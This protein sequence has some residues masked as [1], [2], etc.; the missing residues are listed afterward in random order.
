MAAIQTIRKWGVALLIVIGLGLFAFIAEDFF[1]V[2]DILFGSDKRHVGQVYS[3][4]LG[5]N[6]YQSMIEE[7]TE[8]IKFTRGQ[9]SLSDAEQ[10]QIK[11]QVWQTYVT[12]KLVE[13]E[14]K[15]LGLTVTDEELNNVIKTGTNSMLMQTPFVNKQTGRFDVTLLKQFLDQY[16]QMQAKPDQ[17][18]QEYIEYYQKLYNYWAFIEK[19]LRSSLLNDKYQSL[20]GRSIVSNPISAKLAYEG[21]S[22]KSDAVVASIPYTSV[23]DNEVTVS[24]DDI[25]KLYDQRKDIFKQFG[26]S[27][28]IKYIGIQVTASPDDKA[29][30]EKEM[31]SYAADLEKGENV[32]GIVSTSSSLVSYASLPVSKKAFPRDIQ[33]ELDSMSIG[34]MKGPYLNAADNTLNI[35]KVISTSQVPDSV[36]YRA[37]NCANATLEA[38]GSTADSIIKAIAAGG[39]FEDM[40]KKYNQTGESQWLVSSQYEGQTLDADNSKFIKSIINGATNVVQ[41]VELAQNVILIEVLD[42]KAITTKY[43]AAVIKRTI[44]FSKETYSKAYNA[45]SHFVASNNTLEKMEANA[46]KS[47]YTVQERKD[48]FNYEHYV[49][50]IPST[51]EALR[52]VF[53]AK[54]GDVSQLYECG[55]NDHLLIIS[56]TGIHPEGYRPAS[57]PVVKDALRG[58]A[59]R[60]KKAEKIMASLKGKTVEQA[61]ENAAASKDTLNG[62]TFSSY[63]MVPSTGANEPALTGGISYGKP[64]QNC[65]PVKGNN[66]VY[67]FQVTGRANTNEKYDQAQYEES[68]AESYLRC[69]GQYSNDLYRKAKVKDRRYLYF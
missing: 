27:R 59:M 65:G 33:N 42:R 28:D 58:I 48:M 57:D 25:K 29:A 15:K 31:K 63:A 35:I 11:D 37:I 16:E 66:G 41:K 56:V 54:K 21:I 26:E 45:F 53:E 32:A 1:R 34:S 19:T 5:I 4:K 52:W 62:I 51:R 60:D 8:A 68:V 55:N 9:T 7:Y 30:L 38:A 36:Q 20:I 69:V 6:D 24:D 22:A 67:L 10:N 13:H 18:P 61:L 2:F 39:K 3:N 46:A 50:G 40:A 64:N 47:G 17:V 44:D 12:E 14:A 23:P 49:A 43:D